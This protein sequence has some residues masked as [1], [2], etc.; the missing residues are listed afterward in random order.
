M[1]HP[2]PKIIERI[3]DNIERCYVRKDECIADKKLEETL[4]TFLELLNRGWIRAAEPRN[5]GTWQV[6]QWIKHGILL[7]FRVGKLVPY[8][9]YHP[10]LQFFDKHTLP[11]H[12]FSIEDRV[13]IV[14]GGSAIRSGSYVAPGVICMP[15]MYI[16]IG[17]YV[18]TETMI[19]S[20]VLVGTCAQIGKRVHL[21]A[22]VQIGGVLEPPNAQP[23]IVEDEVFVGG[24][25]GIFE[26]VRIR[27]RAVIAAGVI[28]TNSLPVY[29]IVQNRILRGSDSAPL[30]IPE[31]AVV[32]PGTRKIENSFAAQN[33][34]S[35]YTPIIV[36][37]RDAKTDAKT[38]LENLLR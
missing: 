35:L 14:P 2:D 5:D 21:S 18:D 37:Y 34:L 17:A 6:N 11:L 8:P 33:H 38:I 15:P 3:K 27:K 24:L 7:C 16:N 13:R 30:E 31:G 12:P 23:V 19:D 25:A 9:S 28:L 36:K 10:S 4:N 26:G 29:D 22:G 1:Q 20:H 32:V